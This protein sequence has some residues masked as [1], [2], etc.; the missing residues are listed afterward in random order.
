MVVDELCAEILLSALAAGT[1]RADQLVGVVSSVDVQGRKIIVIV[2]ATDDKVDV[3][4]P[5]GTTLV[6][7]S[8]RPTTIKVLKKGDGVGITHVNGVACAISVNQGPV[9]G[10]V[11]KIDL[12]EKSFVVDEKGTDRDVKVTLASGTTMETVGGKSYGLKDLKSGDGVSVTYDGEDVVTVTVSTK[13]AELTGHVKTVA[14]DLKSLVITPIGT[15]A[16]VTVAVTAK[17]TIVTSEGKTMDL[18]DLKRG[19]GVGVAA[20]CERRV[21]NRRQCR[22]GALAAAGNTEI[23]TERRPTARRNEARGGPAN[24]LAICLGTLISCSVFLAAFSAGQACESLQSKGHSVPSESALEIGQCRDPRI[25]Q[26]QESVELVAEKVPPS[27]VPC[28][29]TKPPRPRRTAL[30]S[31]SAVESS[32]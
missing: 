26:V 23:R 6:T 9:L 15:K 13:P 14:A 21:Q 31:T 5:P 11:E 25:G 3:M 16:E 7:R 20:R 2:E 4:A 30:R 29:S 10:V 32:T 27:P 1:V 17:T 24:S 22:P 28:T 8:G 12:D 19:D 18:K